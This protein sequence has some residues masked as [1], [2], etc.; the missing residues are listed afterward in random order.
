M[1]ESAYRNKGLVNFIFKSISRIAIRLVKCQYFS[2]FDAC[3]W[4]R[5]RAKSA[6]GASRPKSALRVSKSTTFGKGFFQLL[7]LQKIDI[8]P[9]RK[10]YVL[11]VQYPLYTYDSKLQLVKFSELEVG[12]F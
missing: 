1:F 6:S 3:Q 7:N 12:V 10:P 5:I 2:C 9:I 4:S 8:D 11:L